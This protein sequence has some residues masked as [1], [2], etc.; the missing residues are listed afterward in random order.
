VNEICHK[1]NFS[2]QLSYVIWIVLVE[3]SLHTHSEHWQHFQSDFLSLAVGQ[4]QRLPC[5][6]PPSFYTFVVEGGCLQVTPI[7]LKS[8]QVWLLTFPLSA[9][10]LICV[11]ISSPRESSYRCLWLFS[12][13][14]QLGSFSIHSTNASTQ[15]A[16]I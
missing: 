8:L 1:Y 11:T 3:W 14:C 15:A 16:S 7:A 2:L 13:C 12:F 9:I 5:H 6:L 4:I 10:L